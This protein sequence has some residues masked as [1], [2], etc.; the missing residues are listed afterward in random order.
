MKIGVADAA[1]RLEQ[2]GALERVRTNDTARIIEH[3][4]SQLGRDSPGEL[5][6]FYRARIAR[7]GEFHAITPIWNDRVT[8]L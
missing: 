7:V 1:R 3:V 4:R 2:R 6:D 5:E 8:A